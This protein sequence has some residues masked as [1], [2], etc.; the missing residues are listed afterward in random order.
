MLRYPSIE[1]H[2]NVSNLEHWNKQV[3]DLDKRLFAV[4]H[5]IDGANISF[6]FDDVGQVRI[7]TRNQELEHD[8]DFFGIRELIKTPGLESCFQRITKWKLEN[9]IKELHLFGEI[10]GKGIQNRIDY[11]VDSQSGKWI[12]FFDVYLERKLQTVEWFRSWIGEMGLYQYAVQCLKTLCSLDEALNSLDYCI[13]VA[14]EFGQEKI[15]GIVIKPWDNVIQSNG[16]IFFIKIKTKDFCD[17]EKCIIG[18]PVFNETKEKKTSTIDLVEF[19]RFV[20]ETRVNDCRLKKQSWKS[21]SE[22]Y[23][24]VVNDALVDFKKLNGKIILMAEDRRTFLDQVAE[25]C[26]TVEVVIE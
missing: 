6:H 22:F 2:Y 3:P 20:T 4:E 26:K 12:R 18:R 10:F 14:K 24:H 7:C 5:K 16:K 15:E 25:M 9:G 23:N 17:I 21:L 8:K 13:S 19:G 1:N 11:R